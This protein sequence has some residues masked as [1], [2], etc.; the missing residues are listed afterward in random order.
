MDLFNIIFITIGSLLTVLSLFIIVLTAGFYNTIQNWYK[1]RFNVDPI[2][3]FQMILITSG[4][5]LLSLG[6]FF[7]LLAWVKNSTN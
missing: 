6:L 4:L 5:M 7:I 1:E 2:Q 3:T